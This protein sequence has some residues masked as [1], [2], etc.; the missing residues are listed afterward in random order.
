M[1]FRHSI[2]DACLNTADMH[3]DGHYLGRGFFHDWLIA[4]HPEG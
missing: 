1:T 3:V 4:R 2:E